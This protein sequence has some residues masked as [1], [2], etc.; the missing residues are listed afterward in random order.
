MNP[1]HIPSAQGYAPQVVEAFAVPM[2]GSAPHPMQHQYSVG[3]AAAVVN[4]G[5]CRDFLFCEKWPV[6]LQ[7]TIINNMKRIPIRFFICDDS[8]SMGTNDG[9]RL[10]AYENTF[11]SVPCTRWAELTQSLDFHMKLSRAASAPCEFRMLNSCEPLMMGNGNPG[12][13][14][15]AFTTLQNVFRDGPR[16]G[17]PLCRHI[18][19]VIEKIKA[20]EQQL[21]ASR[22]LACVV[23]ACDGESSDGDVATAMAPLKQLPVWVVIRLCTDDDHVVDYWN[24]IDSQLELDMDVLD[25]LTGEAKEVR[26]ANKWLTYGLPIHRMRCV[27]LNEE[28]FSFFL[29]YIEREFDDSLL[30]PSQSLYQSIHITENSASW[31]RSLISLTRLCYPWSR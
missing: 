12:S 3:G 29:I 25:D 20:M 6:G 10:V 28:E 22:Q 27:L 8:G 19:E 17:T 2:D 16:G 21:R 4:E 30:N 14:E 9:N 26:S 15:L 23:I 24:N 7:D 11:K 18:T 1:D 5:G 31:R 13:D